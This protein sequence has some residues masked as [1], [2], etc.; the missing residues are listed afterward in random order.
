MRFSAFEGGD[1][2]LGGVE[3]DVACADAECLVDAAA[4]ER[5]GTRERLHA[6][7]GVGA[8]GGQKSGPFLDRE[9]FPAAIVDELGGGAWSQVGARCALGGLGA[10]RRKFT[11]LLGKCPRR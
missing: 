4:G 8:H 6:R 5:E 3:V 9:V 11:V 7:F 2:D 10:V 1:P